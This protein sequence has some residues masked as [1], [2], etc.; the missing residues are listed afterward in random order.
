MDSNSAT[1]LQVDVIVRTR[2]KLK[3]QFRRVR[4]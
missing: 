4:A 2:K 1:E 3:T